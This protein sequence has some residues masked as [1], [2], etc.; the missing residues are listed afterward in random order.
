[1][2]P[3]VS[4]KEAIL[5]WLKL[6]FIS[7]GGPAGQISMMYDE[8]VEKKK[9]ISEKSFLHALNYTMIL[10]GPEAQQLATYIGWL[11]HGRIGGL[12]AGTL[13]ILPSFF[14]LS[15]LTY[16]Y[17]NYSNNIWGEG[18]LY[19]VKAAV[20]AII[21]SATI[22]IAKKV[23][24]KYYYWVTA[25]FA[26][27]TI[28]IFDINLPIII[29]L[30]GLIGLIFHKFQNQN[31]QNNDTKNYIEKRII[32]NSFI[33]FSKSLLIWSIVFSVVLYFNE[34][35]LVNLSL[36]FSQAALVTFGGAYA[37][38]PYVFQNIIETHGWLTSQQMMDGLALGESTPGPLIMIVTYVGFIVGWYNDILNIGSPLLGAILCASIATFFTF[39]PSFA[40]IFI[41]APIIELSKQNK[42]LEIPLNFITSAVV[43]LIANLGYML[44]YNSLWIDNDK[45]EYFDIQLFILIVLSL[46]ALE[47]AKVGV[48]PL[49]ITLGLTGIMMKV[50]F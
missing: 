39:L 25:L 20:I 42:A 1:M 33:T 46:L 40:F 16:I 30:A 49:L 28:N 29:I 47:K 11:M 21:F 31:T 22:K 13:F 17:I 18:L 34:S 27:L 2:K 45:T 24:K 5:Y 48:L 36:F 9:W 32:K 23:L 43:G 14:I 26:F 50:Y 37:L 12:I 6:G 15:V 38:L 44:A 3:N 7:F 41:G 19:G 4:F 35:I 8:V 10:P